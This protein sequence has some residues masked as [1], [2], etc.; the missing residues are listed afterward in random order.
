MLFVLLFYSIYFIILVHYL[1]GTKIQRTIKKGSLFVALL[2]VSSFYKPNIESSGPISFL[3]SGSL[4]LLGHVRFVCVCVCVCVICPILSQL[5]F[6]KG[7][8]ERNQRIATTK[9]IIA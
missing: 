9:I 1:V 8:K 2:F 3:G 5:V 4:L 6:P 7:R